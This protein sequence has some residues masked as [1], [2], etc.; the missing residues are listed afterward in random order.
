MPQSQPQ[1][2]VW[3]DVAHV[4]I[5]TLRRH[6][7]VAGSRFGDLGHKMEPTS[8]LEALFAKLDGGQEAEHFETP[9]T[10]PSRYVPARQL[11]TVI[12]VAAT[13]GGWQRYDTSR[14]CG[15]LTVI[16]NIPPADMAILKDTLQLAFAHADWQIISPEILDGTISKSAQARF[17][18]HIADRLDRIEPVLILQAQGLLLPRHL[19][20]SG[21]APLP[22]APVSRDVVMTHLLSGSLH[23]QIPDAAALR[24]ALP[25][26]KG[27]ARLDTLE[28]CAALRAP[29]PRVALQ[30]LDAI[31]RKQAKASGPRL[32][33][34]E[35]D[36]PALFAAR[37]IVDD[38]QL[39]KD[40]KA[41]WHEISRSLLLYGPPGTGKTYLARAI[42]NSAGL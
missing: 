32:E 41:G 20:V 11:L 23:D 16:S 12:R 40:G 39:W 38:L 13:F 2:P 35:G 30:R 36:S 7:G 28:T 21:P 17:E 19:L 9:S 31:I 29:A 14:L 18:T 3:L 8:E 15:G 27:L 5:D 34:L 4:A 6:H 42:G 1:T 22:F 37:R 33:E 24:M 26:D 10:V 25:D